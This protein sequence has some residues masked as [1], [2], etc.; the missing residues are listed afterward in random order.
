LLGGIGDRFYFF[1]YGSLMYVKCLQV[2]Q[3]QRSDVND[4][5][6]QLAH[7]L[8]MT[9]FKSFRLQNEQNRDIRSQVVD[10]MLDEFAYL[11]WSFV[12]AEVSIQ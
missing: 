4:E 11:L 2:S 12:V 3:L 1:K 6:N 8:K 10:S 7:L 5:S 9:I